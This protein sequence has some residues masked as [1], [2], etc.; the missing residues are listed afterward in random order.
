MDTPGKKVGFW[1]EN[2]HSI[3]FVKGKF[4]EDKLKVEMNWSL[5]EENSMIS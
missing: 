5:A 2:A 3:S 4:S 1:V